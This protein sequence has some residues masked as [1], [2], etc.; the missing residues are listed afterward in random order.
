MASSGLHQKHKEIE[1]QVTEG[2]KAPDRLQT[3]E[4]HHTLQAVVK[5][6]RAQDAGE[7]R[8]R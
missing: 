7:R 6:F 5:A 4:S 2:D 3:E 8:S 1:F